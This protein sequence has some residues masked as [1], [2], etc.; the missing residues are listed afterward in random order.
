MIPYDR[1][2]YQMFKLA[3]QLALAGRGEDAQFLR[4][5]IDDARRFRWLV[6]TDPTTSTIYLATDNPKQ[7]MHPENI[8]AR[9][10]TDANE[11][12]AKRIA[13]ITRSA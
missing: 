6:A 5:C 2:V 4:D 7:S 13:Q 11:A 8:R 9:I 3:C 10:D 12:Q 1:P